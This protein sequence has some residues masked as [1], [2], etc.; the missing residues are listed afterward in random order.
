MKTLSRPLQIFWILGLLIAG[1][2]TWV[3]YQPQI[4][5]C[6]DVGPINCTAVLH[7]PGSHISIIPLAIIGGIWLAFI[8]WLRTTRWN[9]SAAGLG[10]LGLGWAWWHEWALHAIC[11]W[12]SG[13][14]IIILIFV[15]TSL[16]RKNSRR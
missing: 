2:L 14:Q 7:S 8:P 10:V 9:T 5:Q 1:Y 16:R 4:L 6:P 11:L 3:H 12:C 13:L 15:V